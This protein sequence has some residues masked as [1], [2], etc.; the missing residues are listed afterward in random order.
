MH[1]V[2]PSKPSI[3][4]LA[5]LGLA[6]IA[7]SALASGDPDPFAVQ[8]ARAKL[9]EKFANTT[10]YPADT[11][12]LS[13][14]PP[15][16]PDQKVSGKLRIWGSD[17]FGGAGLKADIEGGFRKFQPDVTFEHNLKTPSLA[18]VGLLSGD[19]DIGPTRRWSWEDLLAYERIY[20]RDPLVIEGMTG[21]AVNPPFAIMVNK[22]NPVAGLSMRQLDGIF[23]AERTGGWIGTA[24]HPEFAR[25]PEGNIRTWGQV[26]LTGEWKA[27]PINLYVYSI[28]CM[29]GPRFSDDVLKGSDQWNERIRQYFNIAQADGTLLT[30]DQQLAGAL[31]RD[32]FGISFFSS[33]R[34]L[35]PKIRAVGI[36]AVDGGPFVDITLQTVR[37][38][39]Y[40]MDDWMY[41]YIN[42][43]PG[44][45][46]DPKIREFMR[47]LLSR[48][49]QEA[50]ARDGKMLPLT[51]EMIRT[52][53]Q[54]LE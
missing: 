50:V 1:P 24:W 51:A 14:L 13:D 54:K 21:W 38:H 18:L 26:G 32:R 48:E 36:A 7:Q 25:G 23:G 5:I 53:R 11:F 12:N 37:S 27:A 39:A 16:V 33:L 3:F 46:L 41:F 47:F 17:M 30:M 52:E 19:A 2:N 15:Y 45:P 4:S 22:A 10:Y 34:G 20:N 28:R 35:D 29:F 40:P 6:A 9:I 8:D 43:K 42:R 44:A 49:A 31:S